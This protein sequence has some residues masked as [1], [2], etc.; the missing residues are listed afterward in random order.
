MVFELHKNFPINKI[1]NFC[2]IQFFTLIKIIF[3]NSL[4]NVSICDIESIDWLEIN[5][6]LLFNILFGTWL[7]YINSAINARLSQHV[8]EL[9]SRVQINV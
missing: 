1:R 8:L 3:F 4:I 9:D 5:L 6:N 7:F 2:I